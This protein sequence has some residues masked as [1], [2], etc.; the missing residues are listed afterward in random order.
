MR[1]VKIQS[2]QQVPVALPVNEVVGVL[3]PAMLSRDSHPASQNIAS[4][5]S[6]KFKKM[7]LIASTQKGLNRQKSASQK[8]NLLKQSKTKAKA[9]GGSAAGNQERPLA[10]LISI[11]DLADLI[12]LGQQIELKERELKESQRT[13]SKKASSK[14][15]GR[16]PSQ[17][18]GSSSF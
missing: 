15:T 2:Q 12:D 17:S 9:G 5:Q 1:N 8:S 16:P 7:N 6:S 13:Q 18:N 4:T 11:P 3:S 14:Q 10:A